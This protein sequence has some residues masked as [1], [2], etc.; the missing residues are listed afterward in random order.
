MPGRPHAKGWAL[1]GGQPARGQ[2]L[3]R[4]GTPCTSFGPFV[5]HHIAAPALQDSAPRLKR[6][7]GWSRGGF[8][9][10]LHKRT[11]YKHAGSVSV[12]NLKQHGP[13]GNLEAYKEYKQQQLCKEEALEAAQQQRQVWRAAESPLEAA[14]TLCERLGADGGSA[15]VG[16]LQGLVR[17]QGSSSSCEDAGNT[18]SP[19]CVASIQQQQQR[20]RR[21]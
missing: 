17:E 19:P 14:D 2:L 9:S 6:Q 11:K 8:S 18:A 7:T 21:Q 1:K 5:K 16:L 10:G 13:P 20:R 3:V 4:C 15:L 12:L